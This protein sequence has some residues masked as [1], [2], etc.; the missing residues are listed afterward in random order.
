MRKEDLTHA[1]FIASSSTRAI[2][3]KSATQFVYAIYT[4]LQPSDAPEFALGSAYPALK[5]NSAN[6]ANVYNLI[7]L[8]GVP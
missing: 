6:W 8:V 2:T 3:S 4:K 5:S 7:L 1:I